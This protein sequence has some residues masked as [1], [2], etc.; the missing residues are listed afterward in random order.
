VQSLLLW[1]IVFCNDDLLKHKSN[2]TSVAIQSMTMSCYAWQ[3]DLW[4]RTHFRG[5]WYYCHDMTTVAIMY[6]LSE[7]IKLHD[8]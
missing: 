4:Q 1:F 2:A 8:K 3:Y 6:D 7:Q 5:K